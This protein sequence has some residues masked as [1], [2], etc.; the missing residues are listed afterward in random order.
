MTTLTKEQMELATIFRRHFLMG[1]KD[2]GSVSAA[3]ND[4]S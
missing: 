2:Y 1:K 3:L 4:P